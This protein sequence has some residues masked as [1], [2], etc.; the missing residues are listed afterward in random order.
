MGRDKNIEAENMRAN[1]WI[2]RY[3]VCNM[4]CL[5]KYGWRLPKTILDHAPAIALDGVVSRINFAKAEQRGVL[6]CVLGVNN[7]V[8][9]LRDHRLYIL[10]ARRR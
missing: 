10:S 8:L 5:I 3:F 4:N 9:F 6:H 7:F 2:R 1:G